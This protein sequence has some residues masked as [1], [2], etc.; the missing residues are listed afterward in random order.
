MENE[1]V[2]SVAD[3]FYNNH[4]LRV[5][6]YQKKNPEKMRAKCKAYNE[7]VKAE[8][9]D[10]YSVVLESKRKYYHEVVKP[11]REA[12]KKASLNLPVIG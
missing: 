3:R 4:K 12:K 1:A 9:P 8:R 5:T 10:V 6:E 7:R 2:L 11:K